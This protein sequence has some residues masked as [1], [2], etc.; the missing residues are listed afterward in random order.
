MT[1]T[2]DPFNA[3]TAPAWQ[4][5]PEPE[6]EPGEDTWAVPIGDVAP[7]DLDDAPYGINP[8]T[9]KPYRMSPEARKAA[10]EKLAAGRAAAAPAGRTAGRGAYPREGNNAS[11][12]TS[13]PPP[14]AGPNYRPPALAL[15]MAPATALA[16]AGRVTGLEVF[17]ADSEAFVDC[18][19]AIAEA[20]HGVAL[21]DARVAGVLDR[22][23]KVSPYGALAAAV[24]TLAVRLLVN[25]KILPASPLFGPEPAG[26]ADAGPSGN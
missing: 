18:A 19:P 17:Y 7:A 14:P 6:P 4:P 25:H 2:Y 9:N 12:R 3:E 13:Q 10:G 1:T 11:P 23:G 20:I 8:A 24:G 16:V 15:L 26:E 5:A 21:E 22:V